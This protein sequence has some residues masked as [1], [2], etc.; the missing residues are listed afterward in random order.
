M[1]VLNV[2]CSTQIDIKKVQ[3]VLHNLN[4]HPFLVN[5]LCLKVVG[6]PEEANLLVGISQAGKISMYAEGFD[7]GDLSTTRIEFKDHAYH[8]VQNTSPIKENEFSIPFDFFAHFYYLWSLE[9]NENFSDS[10]EIFHQPILDIGI[11]HFLYFLGK[12]MVNFP[13]IRIILSHDIDYVSFKHLDFKERIGLLLSVIKRSQNPLNGVKQMYSLQKQ[14]LLD[15]FISTYP[16]SEKYVFVLIGG[17]HQYDFKKTKVELQALRKLVKRCKENGY[18]IG[19]HPSYLAA[20]DLSI[21][22]KEV[23]LFE[24]LFGFKP[25][26]SRQHYLHFDKQ[27]TV[28]NL[29]KVGI[30]IDHTCGFNLGA[31]YKAGTAYAFHYLDTETKQR[32][33]LK[34]QPMHWMDNAWWLAHD[35]SPVTF[36]TSFDNWLKSLSFGEISINVHNGFFDLM[37]CMGVSMDAFYKKLEVVEKRKKEA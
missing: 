9:A 3:F 22:I 37:S 11:L 1:E 5:H 28:A 35:K 32:S 2:F 33:E 18:E 34:A 19:L 16:F 25:R 29:A 10:S 15:N 4:E 8:L 20:Q 36:E 30:Q 23:E 7:A 21:L 13:P 31:G 12:P 17:E 24:E 27:M 14:D 6:S 26:H